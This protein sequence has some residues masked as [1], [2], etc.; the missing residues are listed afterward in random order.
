MAKADNRL[1][2]EGL[3]ELQRRL[4]G[5]WSASASDG[6]SVTIAAVDQRHGALTIHVRTRL[7][8]RD[9][10]P[11]VDAFASFRATPLVVSPYLSESSRARLREHDINYLDLTGNARIVLA[12]PGLFIETQGASQEPDRKE[13]PARSLRGP[14]AGRVIRALIELKAPPGV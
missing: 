4:P 9:V 12:S 6:K 7:A 2:R 11:L 10:R 13:R 3:K 14:K 1:V 8:P 5:G